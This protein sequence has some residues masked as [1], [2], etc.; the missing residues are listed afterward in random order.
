MARY[1]V[2]N[3]LGGTQ[4]A[5]ST[6]YKSL[7]IL[8]AATAT[9]TSAKVFEFGLGTNGTPA[10]NALEW[11][12]ER[13]TAAGTATAITPNALNSVNRAAGTVGAANAT[14]EGTI[15]ANSALFYKGIHQRASYR[16]VASPDSELIIPATN[17]AGF[18][19]RAKSPTGYVGTATLDAKFEE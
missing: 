11:I 8:T 4:Q 5:I 1:A 3:T 19:F 2:S 10:E 14:A 18:A 17:L 16:W 9:L 6:A 13:Q 7:V 12:V 15:T